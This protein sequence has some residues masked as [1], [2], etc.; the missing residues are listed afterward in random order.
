MN[1][2]RSVGVESGRGKNNKK[3]K[4][5]QATLY[6]VHS[7]GGERENAHSYTPCYHPGKT[8]SEEEAC[9]CRQAGNFCEKFCYCSPDCGSR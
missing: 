9:S 8:C 4:T 3:M 6:K 2:G 1:V 7:Q 5:K